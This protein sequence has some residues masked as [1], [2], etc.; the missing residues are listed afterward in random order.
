MLRATQ[1]ASLSARS[2]DPFPGK[3]TLNS[4]AS[5]REEVK[6]GGGAGVSKSAGAP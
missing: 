5:A 2:D 6:G 1:G 4:Y 3:A